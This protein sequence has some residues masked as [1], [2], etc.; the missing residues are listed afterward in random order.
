MDGKGRAA[1]GGGICFIT[2][3]SVL[4]FCKDH[5]TRIL[6]LP[7]VQSGSIVVGK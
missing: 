4:G 7:L 3:S 6:A 1:S 2:A 5:V